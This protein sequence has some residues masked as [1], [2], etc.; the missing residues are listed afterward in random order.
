MNLINPF[1]YAAAGPTDPNFANVVLLCHFDGTNGST[2]FIDSSSVARSV[3]ATGSISL[4]TA[5]QKFGTASLDAG[6]ANSYAGAPF[7]TDWNFGAGQFTVEAWI[8]PTATISGFRGV[9]AQWGAAPNQGWYLGFNAT[10]VAWI[11]STTGTAFTQLTAT[12]SPTLNAWMHLAVDRDAGG[13]LRVYT[14]GTQRILASPP[15]IFN[16]TLGLYIGND[17]LLTHNFVGQ[18]DEVRITKG[19]ARYGGA[20]TPPAAPFPDA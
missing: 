20:F 18:I 12:F 9:V 5:Q 3:T 17:G 1:W 11:Y 6:A 13:I 14:D 4:T 8:R 16:S 10:T 15:A 2:T 7:S 19:V